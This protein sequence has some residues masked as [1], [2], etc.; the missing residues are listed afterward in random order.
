[1]TADTPFTPMRAATI[2]VTEPDMLKLAD[3]LETQRRRPALEGEHM[4]GL[5]QLLATAQVVRE[6]C[7]PLEWHCWVGARETTSSTACRAARE[8]EA[9][10]AWCGLC[11]RDVARAG[12]GCVSRL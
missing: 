7:L 3:L 9:V 1:M 5:R 6:S 2:L 11:V 8:S 12:A 4:G 10:R